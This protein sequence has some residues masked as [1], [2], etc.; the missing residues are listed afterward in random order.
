MSDK[1]L[2]LAIKILQ[3]DI[4]TCV[5]LF[6]K[7]DFRLINIIANRYLENCLIFNQYKLFLPGVFIK[8]MVNDYIG[9]ISNP[10][11]RK[12]INSAKAIGVGLLS[13]IQ[14]SFKDLNEEYLWKEFYKYNL[15]INE[16]LRDDISIHYLKNPQFS[17]LS[18]KF[19][20]DYIES[21]EDYLYMINNKFLEGILDIMVRVI[22][23][24]YSNLKE[25]MVYIYIKF[26]G[27]LYQYIYHENYSNNQLDKEKLKKDLSIYFKYIIYLKTKKEIDTNDFNKNLWEIIKKWR[28]MYIIYKGLSIERDV[29]IPLG[30]RRN[31]TNIQK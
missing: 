13:R 8:D 26:L 5:Y 21:H 6:E 15:N 20:L 16:I 22:R 11:K 14:D 23:N 4:A 31:K 19:L 29:L 18:F 17:S 27:F 10:E 3:Q 28:E 9:I 25:L 2:D 30:L 12:T 1:D 24:H 7:D